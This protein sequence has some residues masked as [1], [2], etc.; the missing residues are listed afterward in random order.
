MDVKIYLLDPFLLLCLDY[1]VI[2]FVRVAVVVNIGGSQM[3]HFQQQDFTQRIGN[4]ELRRFLFPFFLS[5]G[6]Q[7]VYSM[8]NTAV[9]SRYLSQD[10]VALTGACSG[11]VSVI[12]SMF[13]A[14]VSGFG[15]RLSRCIGSGEPEE[16]RQGFWSAAYM[17]LAIG[18]LCLLFAMFPEIILRKANVP[19]AMLLGAASYFRVILLGAGILY[20]KLILISTIQGMGNSVV[21]A[22]LSMAGV[23][24]QT[25]LAVFMIAGLHMGITASAF[26]MLVNNLWQVLV[27]AWFLFMLSGGRISFVSPLYIQKAHYLDTLANGCSKGLM[28]LFLSMGSFFMQRMENRLFTELLAGD[29][30]CDQY[31]SLFTELL[32]VYGTAAVVIVGQNAGR[33]N[34]RLIHE[35]V[36]RLYRRSLAV[37]LLIA[38]L[39]LAFAPVLIRGIAGDGASREAIQAGILQMRIIVISYPLLTALVMLRYSLQAMGDYRA[40]PL[41]GFVEMAVNIGMARMIP[42]MGYMAV[43]LGLALGRIAAGSAAVIRYRWFLRQKRL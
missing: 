34:Y 42:R 12:H 16:I 8:V 11:C 21:P 36:C 1:P 29:A 35:Y 31:T 20:V 25:F 39:S 37:F 43:C 40:M 23:V 14:F 19:E 9:V 38:V 22:A 24:V 10:A 28:F 41:F 2:C 33:G 27:L 17:T 3:K 26:A 4:R 18:I 7:C 15:V 13:P 30:Y 5:A 32:S 6:F